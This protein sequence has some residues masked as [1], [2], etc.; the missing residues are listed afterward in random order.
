MYN[1]G[2]GSCSD[3]DIALA[4]SWS[5]EAL[6]GST[7]KDKF[8]AS[9]EEKRKYSKY[10]KEKVHSSQTSPNFIPLGLLF[11]FQSTVIFAII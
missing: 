7:T 8:A 10:E 3:L 2:A 6:K 4:H 5:E 11:H 1:S 9:I